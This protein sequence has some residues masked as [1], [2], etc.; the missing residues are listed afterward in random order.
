MGQPAIEQSRSIGNSLD[1]RGHCL[2]AALFK[3]NHLESTTMMFGGGCLFSK[4]EYFVSRMFE[5]VYSKVLAGQCVPLT[6]E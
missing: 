1:C 4:E 3:S 6:S 5:H 2:D